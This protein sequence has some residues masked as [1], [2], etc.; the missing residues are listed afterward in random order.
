MDASRTE[1]EYIYRI[2]EA[3]INAGATT[4]N[5]PGYGGLRYPR[6]VR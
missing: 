3:V 6:R 4:V 1:P 2:V 5:I